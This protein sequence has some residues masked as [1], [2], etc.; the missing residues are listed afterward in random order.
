[1][2]V[3]DKIYLD[4]G[5]H[6]GE[7]LE[8]YIEK[9][10]ID[11]SWKVLSFEPNIVSFKE[12][13]KNNKIKINVDFINKAVWT[14]DGNITF[15][16]EYPP[17]SEVSDGAG[18]SIIDLEYWKPKSDNNPGAGDVFNSYEIECVDISKL[19]LDNF[20]VEDIIILKM[21]IEG[22]EFDVLRKMISDGSIKYINDIYVEFHDFCYHKETGENKT[23]LILEIKEANKE[24]NIYGN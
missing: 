11:N 12:L 22:A 13:I 20:K 8:S 6:F 2:Y 10:S 15:N 14:Y 9:Y 19:I 21:D 17:G 4:C 18:S 3:P 7:G 23:N 16:A 1:M 24:I 5:A